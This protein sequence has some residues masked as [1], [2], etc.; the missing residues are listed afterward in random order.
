MVRVGDKEKL[1]F[2]SFTNSFNLQRFVDKIMQMHNL[3]RD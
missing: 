1:T 3:T 2:V